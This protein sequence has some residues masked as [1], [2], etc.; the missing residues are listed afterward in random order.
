MT[1]DTI[2]LG[3]KSL[4]LN[5]KRFDTEHSNTIKNGQKWRE[6]TECNL[7]NVVADVN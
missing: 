3:N 5:T 1:F 7:S 2:R 4:S 6:K